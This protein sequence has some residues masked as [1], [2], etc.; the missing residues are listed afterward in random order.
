EDGKV[1]VVLGDGAG[2]VATRVDVAPV[3]SLRLV[4][5]A[6]VNGDHHLD[7]VCAEV[8][9]RSLAVLIG[10]GKGAFGSTVRTPITLPVLV[11]GTAVGDVTS[12]GRVDVVVAQLYTTSGP[13]IAQVFSGVGDGTFAA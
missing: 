13:T 7:L 8:N 1:T 2:G 11:V 6:D 9:S 5:L 3:V 10:D 4:K 12:D